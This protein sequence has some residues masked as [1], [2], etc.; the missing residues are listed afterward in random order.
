MVENYGSLVL[1]TT[2]VLYL[3]GNMYRVPFVMVM[4]TRFYPCIIILIYK[5]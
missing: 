5:L 4:R 3:Q 1:Y 2:A